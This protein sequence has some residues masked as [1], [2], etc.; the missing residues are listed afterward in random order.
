M[1]VKWIVISSVL[2][3]AMFS[4]AS[5]SA[6]DPALEVG[7][8][9]VSIDAQVATLKLKDVDSFSDNLSTQTTIRFSGKLGEYEV[10]PGTDVLV[11][12]AEGTRRFK[13]AAVGFREEAIGG[14]DDDS[15]VFH[16][17]RM[18]WNLNGSV[19]WTMYALP[20]QEGA[21]K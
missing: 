21:N 10:R 4:T 8:Q 2:S 3:V 18:E 9:P 19:R 16:Y 11:E 6:E 13:F 14:N 20:P 7:K 1:L 17:V 12:L 15:P 5:V